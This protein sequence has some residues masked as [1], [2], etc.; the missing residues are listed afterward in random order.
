MFW[1]KGAQVREVAII[2]AKKSCEQCNVQFLDETV[3]R[4][5][6]RLVRDKQGRFALERNFHFEFSP[7]GHT[8]YRG[9]VQA[10]SN[11]IKSVNLEPYPESMPY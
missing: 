3:V 11:R 4:A 5:G 8:R 7:N 6:W 10:L 9:Q 1:W 2:A